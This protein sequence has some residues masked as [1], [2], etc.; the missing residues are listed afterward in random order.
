MGRGQRTQDLQIDGYKVAGRI[1]AQL[2]SLG[3]PKC[4]RRRDGVDF[5]LPL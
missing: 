5:F 1:L 3:L 2:P 4:L